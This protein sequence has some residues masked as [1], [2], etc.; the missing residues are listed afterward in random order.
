[1][2]KYEHGKSNAWS[3]RTTYA[4]TLILIP[5]MELVTVLSVKLTPE[6]VFAS[7]IL[8]TDIPWLNRYDSAVVTQGRGRRRKR[9][10]ERTRH[11]RRFP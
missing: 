5:Y 7:E 6:T 9:E 1:M 2:C 11:C 10:R 3:E 8:P 4:L